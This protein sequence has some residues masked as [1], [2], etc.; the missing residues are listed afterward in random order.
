MTHQ[1]DPTAGDPSQGLRRDI[2]A[3]AG[4]HDQQ[5]VGQTQG[6]GSTYPHDPPPQSVTSNSLE[7]QLEQ[8]FADMEEDSF[9][10]QPG[11]QASSARG[12]EH[13]GSGGNSPG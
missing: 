6:T 13:G 5:E 3:P 4:T 9:A 2:P 7:Q 11:G 1:I 12:T 10:Q 8:D